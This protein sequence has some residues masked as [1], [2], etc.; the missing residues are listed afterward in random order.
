MKG[1][2][3]KLSMMSYTMARQPNFDL[4]KMFQLTVDLNLAGVDMVSCYGVPATDLRKMGRRLRSTNCRT[5][6]PCCT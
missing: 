1:L 3:M 6:I 5:Y 2:S 4:K